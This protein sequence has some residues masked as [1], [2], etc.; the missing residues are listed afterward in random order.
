LKRLLKG[1][2][3]KPTLNLLEWILRRDGNS[4][5]LGG[6]LGWSW[7]STLDAT[8]HGSLA[9]P[10]NAH[11]HSDLANIG[12]DDHHARDHASRHQDG[13]ADEISVAGLSGEL[14]ERQKSK[15]GDST[16][17]WTAGKVLKGAGA[18]N[19]PTEAD[20]QGY[21]DICFTKVYDNSP[22]P[23]TWTDLNLSSVVGANMAVALLRIRNRDQTTENAYRFRLNGQ[24]Y[25]VGYGPDYAGVNVGT[26]WEE[27]VIYVMVRT[28]T[29]G[30][31]EWEANRGLNTDIWVFAW[32]RE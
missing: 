25:D 6:P 4:L 2:L 7:Q 9:G 12:I 32:W 21:F 27:Q 28:D 29:S 30:I 17:G 3:L 13:G 5:I 20:F 1:L 15:C 23:T 8:H 24:L 19:A 16:L 22:A 11:R 10:A 26:A 31:V 18:G 14:A